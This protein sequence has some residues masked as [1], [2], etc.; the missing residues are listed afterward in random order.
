MCR[1]GR[2]L[3]LALGFAAIQFRRKGYIQVDKYRQTENVE[4]DRI[5]TTA[6][7]YHELKT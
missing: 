2:G 3:D 4:K 1:E 6:V 7:L 5:W